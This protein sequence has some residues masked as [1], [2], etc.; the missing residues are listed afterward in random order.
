M[1]AVCRAL[2]GGKHREQGFALLLVLWILALAS[3]V[4][5]GFSGDARTELT[6]VRNQIEA[7]RARALADAGI[8]IGALNLLRTSE[9][10]EPRWPLDGTEQ[11]IAFGD[12]TV[13]ISLWDEGGKIDLNE[14]P[15]ELLA[16]LLLVLGFA[17]SAGIADAL[18]EW[19]EARRTAWSRAVDGRI[20]AESER[21]PA[22]LSINDLRRVPG[23]TGEIFARL[24]PFVTVHSGSA[25]INPLTAPP[26][27]LTAIPGM[28]PAMVADLVARR[29]DRQPWSGAGDQRYLAAAEAIAVTVRSESNLPSGA[30]FVREAVVV[31]AEGTGLP[32]QILEWRNP[33]GMEPPAMP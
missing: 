32:Y 26:E 16:R 13:R 9:A 21:F 6:V 15:D 5:I 14:A 1:L 23:M 30:R 29:A 20:T 19:R 10:E 28:R 27:V 33:I 2:Q 24:R 8:S 11:E 12:G 22:F 25:S 18:A 7:A 4:L 31:E 17:N 3:V